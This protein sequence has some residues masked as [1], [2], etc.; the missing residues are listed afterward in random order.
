MEI[1]FPFLSQT[2]SFTINFVLC[3]S[4]PTNN[5]YQCRYS[6]LN[7]LA[8]R[9]Q[10]NYE[11]DITSNKLNWCEKSLTFQSTFSHPGLHMAP[12]KRFIQTMAGLQFTLK[13]L[14]ISVSL[15]SFQN[16]RREGCLYVESHSTTPASQIF[17][18]NFRQNQLGFYLVNFKATDT[19]YITFIG[20]LCAFVT[21]NCCDQKLSTP[22]LQPY[23]RVF[24]N[25]QH[26][27]SPTR[28]HQPN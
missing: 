7:K 22:I 10:T 16:L 4:Y 6:F 15:C 24:F 13:N 25:F 19:L 14:K 5:A 9:H 17:S 11:Y 26:L 21:A 8:R 18:S 20:D 27:D 2:G 1:E 3:Q 23:S 28:N 12:D